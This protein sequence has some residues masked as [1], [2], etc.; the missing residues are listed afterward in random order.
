MYLFLYTQD[1]NKNEK[2]DAHKVIN[3]NEFML[4]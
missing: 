3:V 2:I 1:S 4:P